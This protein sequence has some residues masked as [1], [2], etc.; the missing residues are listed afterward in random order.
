MGLLLNNPG[1]H[2]CIVCNFVQMHIHIFLIYKCKY[3]YYFIVIIHNLT[4]I[5]IHN[6][7]YVKGK[8]IEIDKL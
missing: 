8:N 3:L 5:S 2:I 1:S 7:F 6:T 4:F